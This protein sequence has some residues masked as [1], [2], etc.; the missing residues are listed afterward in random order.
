VNHDGRPPSAHTY[1]ANQFI[2]RLD[3][4]MLFGTTALAPTGN[5]PQIVSLNP[6]IKDYEPDGRYPDVPVRV[7]ADSPIC[8]HPITEKVYQFTVNGNRYAI[9]DPARNAWSEVMSLPFR[10]SSQPVCIDKRR[11]R[12]FHASSSSQRGKPAF[13]LD[14]GTHAVTPRVLGGPGTAMF[15]RNGWGMVF[16]QHPTDPSQDCF[17]LRN[18]YSSPPH[19]RVYRVNAETFVVDELATVGGQG[20][21][22]TGKSPRCYNKFLFAPQYGVCV[23][24]SSYSQNAWVLRVL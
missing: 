16:V 20:I 8:K 24:L 15:P 7:R 23:Y 1:Y 13:T 10:M 2:E 9:Y 22:A 21:L 4:A 17:L 12:L 11:N 14:L 18:D 5:Y 19:D 3:R 6:T